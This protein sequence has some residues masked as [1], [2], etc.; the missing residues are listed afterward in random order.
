MKR[1]ILLAILIATFAIG[2]GYNIYTVVRS[3]TAL[4]LEDTWRFKLTGYDP[5]DPFSGRYVQFRVEALHRLDIAQGMPDN[6]RIYLLLD[7]DE[8]GYTYVAEVSQEKPESEG[9]WLVARHRRNGWLEPLFTRYYVNALRAPILEQELRQKSEKAY[10]TVK[11][12]R[13]VGVVTGLEFE[14]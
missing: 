4:A 2:L 8:A 14:D 10:I 7:T 6:A 13:G 3:E 5:Y 12:A 1:A 11:I 9:D